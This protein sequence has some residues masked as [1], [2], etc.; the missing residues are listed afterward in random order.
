MTRSGPAQTPPLAKGNDGNYLQHCV[1]VEAAVRLARVS[2]SGRLHVAL[3][4]GMA[5]FEQIGEPNRNACRLLYGALREAAGE[6]K[7]SEREIVK[8]YRKSWKSQEYQ[9]SNA[10]LFDELKNEK[11]YPNSA[12]LLRAVIGTNRL[13]GGITERDKAKHKELAAAWTDSAIVVVRSSWRQ[14]MTPDGALS[15]PDH[16]DAPWLFSMD[17]MTYSE[18]GNSD[19]ANL[20]R[21][22]SD[23]LVPALER[24]VRSGQPGIASLFVYSVGSQRKNRQRQFWTFMD[25]LAGRLGLRTQSYWV[26][27]QGGNL[28]LTGLLFSD[29]KLAVGFDPPDIAPARG[30]AV[31]SSSAEEGDANDR[32]R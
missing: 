12:E 15:C 17:S 7:C 18:S 19:D 11:R 24:Y 2:P 27:H 30:T 23:L 28:N 26:A 16:L 32:L 6:P 21:S 8:A 3:T 20:N 10:N 13:S 31:S 29:E 5:P 25:E 1:E 4:Q 14:Q 22:D 9:P